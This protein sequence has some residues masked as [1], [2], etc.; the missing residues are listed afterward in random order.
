MRLCWP[1]VVGW[2]GPA[3]GE[4][5][6]LTADPRPDWGPL[7]K[8][9][10][11]SARLVCPLS[12]R[13]LLPVTH[14]DTPNNGPFLLPLSRSRAGSGVNGAPG[15]LARSVIDSGL[16][17]P[18]EER[19]NEDGGWRWRRRDRVPELL[20]ISPSFLSAGRSEIGPFSRLVRRPFSA[21]DRAPTP[22]PHPGDA[23][24]GG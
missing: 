8:L 16:A 5:S 9:V 22:A 21:I 4:V 11:R 17:E 12:E 1:A 13:A 7:G 15:S 23:R 6:E 10:S 24:K 20:R 19:G 18:A 2:R 14:S 3:D